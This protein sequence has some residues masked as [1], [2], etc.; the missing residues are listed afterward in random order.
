MNREELERLYKELIIPESKAPYR[1]EKKDGDN[2]LAYNPVCG[3][4]FRIFT[5]G[6][7]HF[8][9]HG[10]ALSR[11]S[12][13]LLMRQLEQRNAEEAKEMI[14][15]FVAAVKSGTP[16]SLNNDSLSTL[17]ALKNYDGR[18]DCILLT[19]NAMLNYLETK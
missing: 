6:E 9:G 5:E 18:E 15:Q 16:E 4:K 17:V 3:D 10:C 11:A 14:R 1:F 7:I 12:G 2:V 19:W 13:S 8:H